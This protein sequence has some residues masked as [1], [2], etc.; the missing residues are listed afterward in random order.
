M[1]RATN[2]RR[3][4]LSSYVRPIVI[5]SDG[6]YNVHTG[7]DGMV[8][9]TNGVVL[10]HFERGVRLNFLWYRFSATAAYVHQ[11]WDPHPVHTTLAYRPTANVSSSARNAYRQPKASTQ[12]VVLVRSCQDL[13][14]S[15]LPRSPEDKEQFPICAIQDAL[16]EGRAA[17]RVTPAERAGGASRMRR[18]PDS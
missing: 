1:C 12:A 9:V 6:A 2:L 8:S 7:S 3:C 17:Q 14:M 4:F 15:C 5:L 11:P 18:D 16:R 13:H 10:E